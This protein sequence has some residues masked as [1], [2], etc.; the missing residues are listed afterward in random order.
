MVL[1]EF[2][3]EASKKVVTGKTQ[4]VIT[5]L[6][7]IFLDT[8]IP[9]MTKS[10]GVMKT[11]PGGHKMFPVMSLALIGVC[12]VILVISEFVRK[13]EAKPKKEKNEDFRG[14]WLTVAVWAIYAVATMFIGYLFSTL[15]T[16]VFLLRYYGVTSWKR[17]AIISLG[18]VAFVYIIFVRVMQ[19][20]FPSRVLLI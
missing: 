11:L 13:T 18:T 14:F 4:V 5:G 1:K 8:S 12:A 7:K 17:T 16:T 20:P 2:V 10:W 9:K 19:V 6:P 3:T 15:A